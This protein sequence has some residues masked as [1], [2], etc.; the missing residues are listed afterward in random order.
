MWDLLRLAP[1]GSALFTMHTTPELAK[2]NIE[3]CSHYNR[4]TT[5]VHATNRMCSLLL[6][7]SVCQHI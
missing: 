3:C 1:I 5:I 2:R 6:I 4:E 7:V